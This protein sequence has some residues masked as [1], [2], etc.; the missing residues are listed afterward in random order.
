[1]NDDTDTHTQATAA[2]ALIEGGLAASALQF[3]SLWAASAKRGNP[4]NGNTG[5]ILCHTDTE[6]AE[7]PANAGVAVSDRGTKSSLP[8]TIGNLKPAKVAENTPPLRVV[9]KNKKPTKKRTRAKTTATGLASILDAFFFDWLTITAM[10]PATGKGIRRPLA[11]RAEAIEDLRFAEGWYDRAALWAVSQGLHQS[12]VG[13]GTD[14]YRAG[15]ILVSK[16]GSPER[17]ATIRA[18]HATNMPGV[19]IPGGLGLAATLAPSALECL[20]AVLVARADAAFDYS[21]EGLMDGLIDYAKAASGTGAGKGME[22]PS[23]IEKD[24]ARTMYW[25]RDE[26]RVR[27]YQ[28]DL[29]R[30][31]RG[32]IKPADADPNLI[33]VE[34]IFRPKKA[35]KAAFAYLTPGQMV[36]TSVWARRMVEH[37]GQLIGVAKEGDMLARQ[38]IKGA[39]D[40][41]TY[42]DRAEAGVSMY[43]RTLCGAAVSRLVDKRFGGDWALAEIRP[44]AVENEVL[45]MV[46][47][48]LG[49]KGS[50]ATFVEENGLAETMH[51]KQ[52][53]GFM[54]VQMVDFLGNQ[55]KR[56]LEAQD[57][58]R[59]A[60]VRAG[61]RE[62][63]QDG[64]GSQSSDV[65]GLDA[66]GSDSCESEG[67]AFVA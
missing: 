10:N 15:A 48:V 45:A 20:G 53:A 22:P 52:R 55:A 17:V 39:P 26:V 61:V 1:M 41:R 23:I 40:P 43:A 21:H 27:I 46:R 9:S 34:F 13:R 57:A 16:P 14:G 19:E 42:E 38:P 66:G 36:Q 56:D 37:L 25:G 29:E 5:G 28:K 2:P 47:E 30:V 7:N 6:G 11:T 18:G 65:S 51:D 62:A 50:A 64:E 32:H 63:D 58:L 60:L 54:K 4:P 33:R 24:G 12:R 59:A 3:A 8:E 67:D 31:A 44:D 35:K 49:K